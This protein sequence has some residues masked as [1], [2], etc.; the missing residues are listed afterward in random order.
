MEEAP[1]RRVTVTSSLNEISTDHLGDRV[2]E[3]G[4]GDILRPPPTLMDRYLETT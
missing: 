3:K 1:T 4:G 2:V